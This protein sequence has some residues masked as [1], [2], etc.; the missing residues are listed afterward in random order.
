MPVHL[1][2]PVVFV[3]QV[4][5]GVRTLTGVATSVTASIGRFQEHAHH[6]FEFLRLR[7]PDKVADVSGG[8]FRLVQR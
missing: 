2:H 6:G 1:G 4:P 5:S 8:P 7:R 3:E